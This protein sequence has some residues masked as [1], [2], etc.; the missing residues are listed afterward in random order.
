MK[1]VLGDIGTWKLHSGPRLE[2]HVW[3]GEAIVFTSRT[4]RKADFAGF[5][6]SVRR[7]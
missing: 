4:E 1:N 2:L 3:G 5:L 6:S 7:S